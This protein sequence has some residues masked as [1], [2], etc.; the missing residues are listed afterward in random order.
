R[1]DHNPL[2]QFLARQLLD[3]RHPLL[4]WHRSSSA[5][6]RRQT[7]VRVGGEFSTSPGP[8]LPDPGVWFRGTVGKIKDALHSG[9]EPHD[10]SAA[11]TVDS[12]RHRTLHPPVERERLGRG[13][14]PLPSAGPRLWLPC[15][16]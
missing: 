6:I 16:A 8:S 7:P 5:S 13:P 12:G 14:W 3:G 15:W 9:G 1:L 11:R 10:L 2:R 4:R